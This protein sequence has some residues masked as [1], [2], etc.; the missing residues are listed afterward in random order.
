MPWYKNHKERLLNQIIKRKRTGC[1]EWK[2]ARTRDGY[3]QVGWH[4]DGKPKHTASHR[5]SYATFVGPI[6]PGFYVCH[7]CDNKKCI[8]PAH[9]F[10]GT[11]Q[12]NTDDFMRKSRALKERH[13]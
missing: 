12:D 2:G 13:I 1:W 4:E 9:L 7:R 6:P 11:P 5:L 3:G 8:N 10:A